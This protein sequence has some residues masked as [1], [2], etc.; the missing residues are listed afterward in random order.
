MPRFH[1]GY[2]T[3]T[4]PHKYKGKGKIML[5]SSWEFTVANFFDS[6]ENILEWNSEGLR[7][8]YMHPFKNKRSNYVPDFMIKYKDATG[9]IVVEVIEVKPKNQSVLKE[10]MSN[11]A[12]ETVIIN[13][14]KW[15]AAKRFCDA[16]NV[17]FRVMT[18]DQIY[19]Q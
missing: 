10:G 11:K 14:A 6:N 7:I 17:G 3:P 15:D 8:P 12:K 19:R 9:K 13:L 16:N 18:E 1:Q 4:N 2:F 5:R